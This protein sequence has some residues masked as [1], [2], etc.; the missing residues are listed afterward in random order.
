MVR[1]C[2][3]CSY[4]ATSSSPTSHG[5]WRFYGLADDFLNV[6]IDTRYLSRLKQQCMV[7]VREK[8]PLE[9][10]CAAN[11]WNNS[12]DTNKE[13][14][15]VDILLKLLNRNSWNLLICT[16]LALC[17]CI[18]LTLRFTISSSWSWGNT[19]LRSVEPAAEQLHAP[20]V[21]GGMVDNLTL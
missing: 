13:V 16:Y 1:V 21:G 18:S 20:R 8:N 15:K 11:S 12:P 5:K 9:R 10:K 4:C 17:C 14:N 3:S 2:I 7:M 19:F 6:M